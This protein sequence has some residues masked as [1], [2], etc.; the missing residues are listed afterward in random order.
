M[1]AED[2]TQVR[3]EMLRRR[4]EL[5]VSPHVSLQLA[6]LYRQTGKLAEAVAVLEQG[7]D[8]NPTSVSLRVALGRYRME[9][10]DHQGATV[11]LREVVDRD[12]SHLVA[13]K[14][15]VKSYLLQGERQK[16]RDRLDLYILL[17]DGD[18]EIETL[19]A[20]VASGRP[21]FGAGPPARPAPA[22][23]FDLPAV[24][25]TV[26]L[27]ALEKPRQA[28]RP[29][30]SAT[31]AA[32]APRIRLASHDDPF[33]G[34]GAGLGD[35]DDWSH[36]QREGIFLGPAARPAPAVNGAS[37]APAHAAPVAQPEV[38]ATLGR[39][40]LDQG[41]LAEAEA[42]FSG[43]LAREPEHAEARTGMFEIAARRALVA[44]PAAPTVAMAP[45]LPPPVAAPAPP[46]P[47]APSIVER[48]IDVLRGYLARLR[49][50][51]S[52]EE[53]IRP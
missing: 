21:L 17:N 25:T 39:L 14:L 35:P 13:N 50:A 23:P 40:Y 31:V 24:A 26:D 34:L 12:P 29:V 6:D 49:R 16:A 2:V 38:T 18:P 19:E 48:K 43:L 15:L 36:L 52:P 3:I 41:H 47:V 1:A 37:A 20:S 10:G 28:P 51:R 33:A 8:G 4:W 27:A 7:L 45:P 53:E 5:T 46:V 44:K 22:E 9:G 11:A 30:P 42:I 32:P